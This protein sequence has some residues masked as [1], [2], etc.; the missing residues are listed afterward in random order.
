MQ[1]LLRCIYVQTDLFVTFIYSHVYLLTIA[2][3]LLTEKHLLFAI[4]Y[5][6]QLFVNSIYLQCSSIC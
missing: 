3:Y 1:C 5:Y 6:L 2:I 4:I